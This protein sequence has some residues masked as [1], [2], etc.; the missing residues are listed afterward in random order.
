MAGLLSGLTN[1]QQIEAIYVAYFGRAADGTGYL[2]WGN[3]AQTMSPV[4]IA[5]SF[6][7]QPE[8]TSMYAFLASPPH[9]LIPTDPVQ[10]AAVDTFINQVYQNL[11][12][13]AADGPG[14]LYWQNQILTGAVSVGAAVY[15]IGNG[16]TGTDAT[17]LTN[18]I[19]AATDFTQVT[20]ADNL[21]ASTP[22]SSSFLL[23]AHNAVAPVTS[24]PA[25]VTASEAATLAY[26]TQPFE[27]LDNAGGSVN[28]SVTPTAT[29]GGHIAEGSALTFT[30]SA[31][32][33]TADGTVEHFVLTG[34]GSALN[35]ITGPL[36]GD[37]TIHSGTA[38]VAVNTVANVLGGA[39]PTL[40]LTLSN[41]AGAVA[42][43][44]I[45]INEAQQSI[46][47]AGSVTE[48]GSTNFTVS[49]TGVSGAAVQGLQESYT[50]SGSPNLAQIP[51]ADRSGVITLDQNGQAV[52]TVHTGATVFNST[53][54]PTFTMNLLNAGG[55]V[56]STPVTITEA[57]LLSATDNGAGSHTTT[58]TTVGSQTVETTT[59][60]A[61]VDGQSVTFT[62]STAGV[63]GAAVAG[64]QEAW[65]LSGTALGEVAGATS[66]VVT[67]DA[68]GAASVTVQTNFS[69]S[70]AGN[71]TFAI[72]TNNVPGVPDVV[73]TVAVNA[74]TQTIVPPPSVTSVNEGSSINLSVNT[75]SSA[76][77]AGTTESY[78]ITGTGTALAQLASSQTGTVTLDAN[79]HAVLPVSTS[80]TVFNST[81]APTYTV[82]LNNGAAVLPSTTVTLNETALLSAT[83]NGVGGHTPG[84]TTV[85]TQHVE[86]TT[87]DTI[88]DGQSV[89]FTVAT[90]G[91]AGAAGAGTQEAWS[92]SGSALGQV[93]G[94]T[95]GVVTLDANGT[96]SVTVQ[97]NF[98]TSGG[99]PGQA[100]TFAINTNNVVGV[101]D[102][103]DTVTVNPATQTIA[104]PPSVTSVNEGSSINFS[105]NTAG[106][107]GAAVAGTQESYTITGTG[108]AL[109]QLASPQ[110]GIVTLDA[111]G[112]AVLPVS[113][114]ATVFNSTTS[115][116]YTVTLNNGAAVLPTTTIHINETAIIQSTDSAVGSITT[117]GTFGNLVTET[118]TGG[119]I[120][121]GSSVTFTIAAS[122]VAGAAVAGTQEAWTLSD[123]GTGALSQVVGATSG[124][125]T[126]DANGNATVTVQTDYSATSLFS[127][128]SLQLSLTALPV[129]DTVTVNLPPILYFTTA[130][131]EH[132][133]G[134]DRDTTFV[135]VVDS[136]TV[137]NNTMSNG[138]SA[139]GQAG[140]TNTLDVFVNSASTD[141]L[142][143]GPAYSDSN[144]QI[145]NVT[146]LNPNYAYDH[147]TGTYFN[148]Q[149]VPDLTLIETSASDV[150]FDEFFNVQTLANVTVTNSDYAGQ[151]D[152]R[153]YVLDDPTLVAGGPVTVTLQNAGSFDFT[154]QRTNGADLVTAFNFVNVGDNGVNLIGAQVTQSI[155]VNGTGALW[156]H[157]DTSD[158]A[159]TNRDENRLYFLTSVDASGLGEPIPITDNYQFG[160]DAVDIYQG[161]NGTPFTFIGA[162]G[163]SFVDLQLEVS[164]LDGTQVY[165]LP[166]NYQYWAQGG[167]FD[168][169]VHGTA[170]SGNNWVRIDSDHGIGETITVT[171]GGMNISDTTTGDH[172]GGD[173]IDLHGWKAISQNL[174]VIAA[175]GTNGNNQINIVSADNANVTVTQGDG[176]NKIDIDLWNGQ[177]NGLTAAA[178]V[179]VTVG[180]GSNDI[181]ID[182]DEAGHTHDDGSNVTVHAGN[183][184]YNDIHI[185]EGYDSMTNVTVGSGYGT[186]VHVENWGGTSTS[187][188][189]TVGS[190]AGIVVGYHDNSTGW[191]RVTINLG[192]I[193][194]GGDTGAGGTVWA[195]VGQYSELAE[196]LG[197]GGYT[198][199]NDV[200][201]SHSSVTIHALDLA[202]GG[203][204]IEVN[205]NG[206]V[207]DSA[208]IT[209]GG[210]NNT[211]DVWQNSGGTS[212][213][214]Y[215]EVQITTHDAVVGA[216]NTISVDLNGSYDEALVTVGNGNNTVQVVDT[217]SLTGDY[218]DIEAGNGT[219]HITVDLSGVTAS[220]VIVNAGS[221]T[222]TNVD[223]VTVALFGDA[224]S[225]AHINTGGGNDVITVTGTGSSTVNVQAGAGN[226]WVGV[227]SVTLPSTITLNGGT[228]Y[229]TVALPGNATALDV[230]ALV[231]ASITN[232]QAL[233]LTSVMN[234]A[235][236]VLDLGLSNNINQVILDAGHSSGGFHIQ[237]L[238]GL[239][240][241]A[242]ID[243]LWGQ[244]AGNVL[245]V[246]IGNSIP[247]PAD[248][249]NILLDSQYT[250]G[251]SHHFGAVDVDPLLA[252][253][254][255]TVNI[256]STAAAG[257]ADYTLPTIATNNLSLIDDGIV[258][259]NIVGLGVGGPT[260]SMV[261]GPTLQHGTA[262]SD[263]DVYLNLDGSSTVLGGHF[264]PTTVNANTFYA[265]I[266]D[267]DT[268][269]LSHALGTDVAITFN[270]ENT[271]YD[272]LVFGNHATD[273]VH[274]GNY[275]NIVTMGNGNSD[276][277]TM[278]HTANVYGGLDGH[279]TVT[280]GNGNSDS[281][282]LG[283]G[284]NDTVTVGDGNSD[285]VTI[286]DGSGDAVTVGHGNGDVITLGDGAGAISSS[287]VTINGNNTGGTA[288]NPV[289]T[290][291]F[292]GTGGGN[293]VT[294]NYASGTT[295]DFGAAHT[296]GDTAVFNH[297]T[298]SS[299]GYNDT[300]LNFIGG[301]GGDTINLHAVIAGHVV[302]NGVQQAN[303]ALAV[304]AVL[305]TD[306]LNGTHDA[307]IYDYQNGTLYDFHGAV[308]S[309][310]ITAANTF[311]IQLVGTHL[312]VNTVALHNVTL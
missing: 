10:I 33:G 84:Q 288:G 258:T 238:S 59:G 130:P 110:T 49:T 104:P 14:L 155:T 191:D 76:G 20:F 144:I 173:K 65:S 134:G 248:T 136:I 75:N 244:S 223:T 281:I 85:G 41:Q 264:E 163:N 308:T 22:L 230:V 204:T 170:T 125:V 220:T 189:I 141:V 305:N 143:G 15:T 211:I 111:N 257:Q 146:D 122:G 21:G 108:T 215:A 267:T 232:F 199:H 123:L 261:S 157:L 270:A 102:V 241:N 167:T 278:V 287:T 71:L 82:T 245:A 99:L 231:G 16:A 151:G 17:T 250:G 1:A 131:N 235:V 279:N 96:A 249:V 47:A 156:L 266:E 69:T 181:H 294:A 302:T 30:V 216:H 58:P 38:T 293:T 221:P 39:N 169:T 63:V 193:V 234:Q 91:V 86:T 227:D 149:Y 239:T 124:T 120:T 97:T 4:A 128:G 153:V 240:N 87:G 198:L 252:G 67:L 269:A 162:Q 92:L 274:L 147:H 45:T 205:L 185:H 192:A 182:T 277:L 34:T 95:S 106:V 36:T 116:T 228:G 208:S 200:A 172:H 284:G 89:T 126:L 242:E 171:N 119:A 103:V 210:G 12:N 219:N 301:T 276:V 253:D 88:V 77:A 66:G 62:V 304:L 275:N 161:A 159:I 57:A 52:V 254:I 196:N 180:D 37:V 194:L 2:Y 43:D 176:N 307:V 303:G 98:S 27:I 226:D 50:L 292:N 222:S 55:T 3:A 209:M 117:Q 24:V 138:E 9:P 81:T 282:T 145:V 13:R 6:A 78:T 166:S 79:G 236:D 183:G 29:T 61:I 100:L 114:L 23:A 299:V 283:A 31:P 233:E 213:S 295:I 309:A 139:Q 310:N 154:Y 256:Q 296:V 286:G 109:A 285:S 214:A 150:S 175:K 26:T 201:G 113:T 40:T 190:G 298:D 265:G 73:D 8:A 195:D 90:T 177:V 174:S 28:T 94:P 263:G 280:V 179:A 35:Q 251:S 158:N 160:F 262:V 202:G 11:F 70:A 247:N 5:N 224:A 129:T 311:E 18:K 268:G 142:L 203:D 207:L 289:D 255:H 56:S 80:A 164:H 218:V 290:V 165:G 101:P 107:S 168:I 197:S 42:T 178:I 133:V 148:M 135:G 112:R 188:N 48:G 137:G 68:N 306:A 291:T 229:N 246:P 132:L 7:V 259:L 271:T 93:A 53:T 25:T 60:G 187:A 273:F 74:A 72:N 184:D 32:A 217:P 272:N 51:V 64:T 300:I 83:D 19:T 152:L 297:V 105:V 127:G 115:P 237:T 121:D 44:V 186:D 225:S 212:S 54:A 260:A 312:G 140:Y 243:L 118:T 206:T 46:A